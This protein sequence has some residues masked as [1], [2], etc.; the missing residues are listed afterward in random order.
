VVHYY[1]P[2]LVVIY[3]MTSLVRLALWLSVMGKLIYIEMERMLKE[4]VVAHLG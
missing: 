1:L 4:M 2:D 3:L